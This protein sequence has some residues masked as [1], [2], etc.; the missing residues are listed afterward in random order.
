ML[1]KGK[2][3]KGKGKSNPSPWIDPETIVHTVNQRKERYPA[4]AL[5]L[6]GKAC[7]AARPRRSSRSRCA[8]ASRGI[9]KKS[10]LLL[11][12]FPSGGL[13]AGRRKRKAKEF[14][15]PLPCCCRRQRCAADGGKGNPSAP[16]DGGA[17]TLGCTRRRQRGHGGSTAAVTPLAMGRRFWWWKQ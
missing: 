9:G 17:L 10:H 6:A 5:G 12:V 16:F 3:K 15:P 4:D 14:S 1:G 2:A 8:S 7:A 13:G 11:P